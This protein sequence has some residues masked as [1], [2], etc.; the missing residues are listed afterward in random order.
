MTP[1]NRSAPHIKSFSHQ[2]DMP[3]RIIDAAASVFSV[4]G[5]SGARVRDIVREAD[6]NQAAVNYYFGGKEGLYAATISHLAAARKTLR[7]RDDFELD[8]VELLREHIAVML[9]R[10]LEGG[11]SAKLSRIIAFEMRD[12]TPYFDKVIKAAVGPEFERLTQLVR[13]IAQD[14]VPDADAD[15]L[16]LSVMGQCYWYLFAG[17]AV[18]S[19]LGYVPD[20]LEALALKLT[21]FS[22]SAI[23]DLARPSQAPA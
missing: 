14:P 20:D 5:F 21:R 13:R 1:L 17:P 9:R 6:V 8:P 10:S 18:P 16:A 2:G 11:P 4:H 19:L 3:Q 22:V 23:R 15:S 7:P 12:P